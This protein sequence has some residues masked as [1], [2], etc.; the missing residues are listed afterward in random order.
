MHNV[1]SVQKRF[2]PW[3]L[4]FSL[5]QHYECREQTFNFPLLTF[6]DVEVVRGG[7]D[8]DFTKIV[9]FLADLLHRKLAFNNSQ[10]V[11]DRP[12]LR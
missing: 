7:G 8:G 6:V 12:V 11:S 3:S 1:F 5:Q 2:P 10:P 9:R 4:Q